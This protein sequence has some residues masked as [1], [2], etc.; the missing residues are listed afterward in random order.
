ML[1]LLHFLRQNQLIV[2]LPSPCFL[3][4]LALRDDLTAQLDPE[5]FHILSLIYRTNIMDNRLDYEREQDILNIAIA[6][7]HKELLV[8]DEIRG[9]LR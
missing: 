5:F 8:L 6:R 3:L 4:L 2:H 7:Q 1:Q 9:C